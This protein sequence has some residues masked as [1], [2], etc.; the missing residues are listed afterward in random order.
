MAGAL[1][2][3]DAQG[4][5]VCKSIKETVEVIDTGE[6]RK[7]YIRALDFCR[8][9]HTGGIGKHLLANWPTKF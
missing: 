9:R 7:F 1:M 4:I 2:N 6:T 3:L 8:D 5:K